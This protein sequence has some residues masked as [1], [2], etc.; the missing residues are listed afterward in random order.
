M[1][2]KDPYWKNWPEF[3][4][5][6]NDQKGLIIGTYNGLYMYVYLTVCIC[7]YMFA[8][9]FVCVHSSVCLCVLDNDIHELCMQCDAFHSISD[10]ISPPNN[11]TKAGLW[12]FGCK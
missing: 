4:T 5:R 1:P 9:R 2:K 12:A 7:K 8:L 10:L 11:I 3:T 6:I